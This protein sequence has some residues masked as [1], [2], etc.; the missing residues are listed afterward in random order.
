MIKYAKME[1]VVPRTPLVVKIESQTTFSECVHII[2]FHII[3]I[4]G[5]MLEILYIR[6]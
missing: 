3:L 4:D 1:K 6:V 5:F 2:K